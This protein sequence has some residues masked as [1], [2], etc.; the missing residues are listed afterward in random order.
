MQADGADVL[1]A[2]SLEPTSPALLATED[3]T[4]LKLYIPAISLPEHLS[5]GIAELCKHAAR[6]DTIELVEGDG[7]LKHGSGWILGFVHD[8]ELTSGALR[9]TVLDP[10]LNEEGC[11]ESARLQITVTY[12][13]ICEGLADR[14][15][16]QVMSKTSS[17]FRGLGHVLAC[18]RYALAQA[19]TEPVSSDDDASISSGSSSKSPELKHR[20]RVIDM[21]TREEQCNF[22]TLGYAT[23]CMRSRC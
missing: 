8:S 14:M 20:D 4:V 6:P 5:K 12:K 16:L 17:A 1:T 3:A 13:R 18:T 11:D 22:E 23:H 10:S 9:I 21:L 2:D 15:L 19:A 7:P